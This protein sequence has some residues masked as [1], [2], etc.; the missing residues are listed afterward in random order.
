VREALNHNIH[1]GGRHVVRSLPRLCWLASLAAAAPVFA[2]AVPAN[3]FAPLVQPTDT[4]AT[5]EVM[6]AAILQPD[7]R[8]YVLRFPDHNGAGRGVS[9]VWDTSGH[10][11]RYTDSR[12]DLRGPPVTVAERGPRTS[13]IID[14][15]K[16]MA[17]LL[18]E[19]Y[20]RS[21]GSV[22]TTVSDAMAA[23]QLGPPAK[24]LERLH[25]QCGAP[26]TSP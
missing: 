11:R 26:A 12:G 2:Q 21:R 10:L 13:I 14:V 9:A 4:V 24:L 6:T 20:G 22:M 23:R 7:E 16:G 8:G 17:L 15:Q 25:T 5:C 3:Q 1:I 19:E 18:N